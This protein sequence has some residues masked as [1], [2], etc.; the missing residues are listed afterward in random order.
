MSLHALASTLS[1]NVPF[2]DQCRFTMHRPI[3]TEVNY[4]HFRDM[5]FVFCSFFRRK[6]VNPATL[7]QRL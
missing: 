2:L 5:N 1:Y 4:L 7:S 3:T 6:N